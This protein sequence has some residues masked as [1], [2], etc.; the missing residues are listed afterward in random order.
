[1]AKIRTFYESFKSQSGTVIPIFLSGLI[2]IV[3]NAYTLVKSDISDKDTKN[4]LYAEIIFSFIVSY[5]I[6]LF[7][8]YIFRDFYW[9]GGFFKFPFP[10]ILL[11]ALI[12]ILCT[13]FSLSLIKGYLQNKE[14][15]KYLSVAIILS[16]VCVSY[17]IFGLAFGR[18][19]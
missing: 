17:V 8:S 14:Y 11:F 4:I 6:L 18:I 13:P 1:M 19:D 7:M 12:V 3:L 15:N 5:V 2:V 10:F 16:T 9:Y